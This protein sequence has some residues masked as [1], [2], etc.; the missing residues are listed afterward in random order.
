MTN[1]LTGPALPPLS[2][3]KP[4]QLVVI[5]HGYGAD[6]ANLIGLGFEWQQDLPDAEFLAPNAHQFCEMGG[7]G[8]QWFS[9][10]E[11]SRE[12]YLRG[13]KAAA[14]I[15]DAYLDEELKKR[16]LSDKDLALVGFSQ[17]TMMSLYNAP[18]RQNACAGVLGYSG[19]L[20]GEDTLKDTSAR[21]PVR[22]VHG[23]ADDVVPFE[24]MAHAESHL[25]NAGFSVDSFGRPGLPHSIDDKGIKLGREFLKSVF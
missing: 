4:K 23:E 2:G 18:R 6:G 14:P 9:L 11:R 22:L 17:G 20:L 15:L 16:D 5:L 7:G 25:S 24:S 21:P 8:Y 3:N 19:R 13:A 1:Q 12:N 10:M